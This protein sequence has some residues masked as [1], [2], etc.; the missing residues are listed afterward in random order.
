MLNSNPAG[1]GTPVPALANKNQ[2]RY[3]FSN[4]R[5]L[6]ISTPLATGLT[7]FRPDLLAH[8]FKLLI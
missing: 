5:F 2:K 1:T 4:R 7:L 8:I 6:N 3:A